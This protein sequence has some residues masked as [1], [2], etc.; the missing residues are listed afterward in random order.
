LNGSNC[1]NPPEMKS[2]VRVTSLLLAILFL[3][4]AAFAWIDLLRH[5]DLLSDARLKP[6]SAWL[7]TGLMFLAV[8]IRGWRRRRRTEISQAKPTKP[9]S[10]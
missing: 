9:A 7:M 4:A 6:A 5:G 1:L 2:F 10:E 3:T 8:G